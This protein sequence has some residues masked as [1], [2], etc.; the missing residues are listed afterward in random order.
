M[1]Y[2]LASHLVAI[3]QRKLDESVTALVWGAVAAVLGGL[4][5]GLL[6]LALQ[7]SLA[8]ALGQIAATLILGVIL[9]VVA[10]IIAVSRRRRLAATPKAIVLLATPGDVAIAPTLPFLAFVASFVAAK[11]L[12]RMWRK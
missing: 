11:A 10:A 4:G 5:F 3:A 2:R 1:P 6:L 9:L 7:M 8:A 12:R